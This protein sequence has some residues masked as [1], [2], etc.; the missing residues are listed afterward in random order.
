MFFFFYILKIGFYFRLNHN[1]SILKFGTN[2]L[3]LFEHTIRDDITFISSGQTRVVIYEMRAR[4]VIP[5]IS[6]L[7]KRDHA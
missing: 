5:G 7:E 3:F 6:D 1:T 2:I 4:E